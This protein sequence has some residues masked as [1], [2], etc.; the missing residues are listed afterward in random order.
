MPRKALVPPLSE[1]RAAPGGVASVDRA[2]SLLNAFALGRETLTLSELAESTRQYKSTVLR[3]LA[4]LE[5]ANLVRRHVDGRFALG[6][7]VARLNAVYSASFSIGEVVQP[8][9][10]ELVTLTR[11]SASFHVQQ[12]DQDLC[13]FRADS[14]HTVRDHT[15]AGDM[16][17]LARTVT[18]KVLLA[19][20]S[21]KGGGVR[22]ARIRAQHLLVADGDIVP[23][24]A[25][26]VAP[27]FA[28]DRGLAGVL[29]LTLPSVRLVASHAPAV[30]LMAR[31]V[32]QQLGGAYPDSK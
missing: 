18:G 25:A 6:S 24:L 17:P 8:A 27:V 2:L 14:P 13:L 21:P 3:L 10:Q 5:N 30:Q 23:E 20:A 16:R 12:G 19:Y 7:A 29:A 28:P 32:T 11:E 22:G 1:Q 15:R 9:I 31:H 26:I 4:S